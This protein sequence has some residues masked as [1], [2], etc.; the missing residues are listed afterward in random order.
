MDAMGVH[1]P[2]DHRREKGPWRDDVLLQLVERGVENWADVRDWLRPRRLVFID[3]GRRN[4]G[5]LLGPSLPRYRAVLVEDLKRNIEQCRG[6]F[7][8]PAPGE[9]VEPIKLDTS[10]NPVVT[11]GR[12]LV[13]LG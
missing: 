1:R 12:G 3:L 8:R 6:A 11:G 13:R 7:A 10:K 4:S 9:I 5:F 2:H